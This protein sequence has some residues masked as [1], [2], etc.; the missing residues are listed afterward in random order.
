MDHI[1]SCYYI[2][3]RE[4]APAS[5]YEFSPSLLDW[6]SAQRPPLLDDGTTLRCLQPKFYWDMSRIFSKGTRPITWAIKK[7]LY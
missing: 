7:A 6:D 5:G 3:N 1:T 4:S 2:T